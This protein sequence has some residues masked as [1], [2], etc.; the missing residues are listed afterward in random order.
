MSCSGGEASLMA[1]S[2]P[3]SNL[4]FP[5]LSETQQEQ[6]REALGPL[7][8]L[9]K[10]LDYHTYIWGDFQKMSMTFSAMLRGSADLSVLVLDFPREDVCEAPGWQTAIDA[11]IAARNVTGAA[12]GILASVPEN[13]PETVAME[14]IETEIVPFSGMDE[15]IKA[16]EAAAFIGTHGR[17]PFPE[18]TIKAVS[19]SDTGRILDESQAKKLLSDAGLKIPGSVQANSV[20]ELTTLSRALEFPLVLKGLGIAHKT[21]SQAVKLGLQSSQAVLDAGKD[22]Q[23]R[24][25]GFL[26]E[27]Y[28]D[29]TIAELLVSIVSDPAHGFMLTLAAGGVMTEILNDAVHLLLPYNRASVESALAGLKVKRLLD[30]YRGGAAADQIKIIETIMLL[31]DFVLQHANEILEV[32]LIHCCAAHKGPPWSMR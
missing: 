30:G 28:I 7:V 20:T 19:S 4:S 10:S 5:P 15:A 6:L 18:P 17:K 14:L 1:D 3:D 2:L 31:Q 24:V 32:E 16:M 12:A 11:L 13:M 9:A 25:S 21:E 26:L 29:D 22:M 27:E 23:D 8:A